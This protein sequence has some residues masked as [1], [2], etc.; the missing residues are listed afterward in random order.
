M[1]VKFSDGINHPLYHST[2]LRHAL[3]EALGEIEEYEQISPSV[4]SAG[5]RKTGVLLTNLDAEKKKKK[6]ADD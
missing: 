4:K 6:D 3:Q 2:R 5:L 1:F